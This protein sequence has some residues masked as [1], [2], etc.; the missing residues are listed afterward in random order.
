[1]AKFDIPEMREYKRE[2]PPEHFIVEIKP[3][4][5]LSNTKAEKYE[6]GVFDAGGYRWR[7]S[8]YPKYET[9]SKKG[10]ISL[11]LVLIGSVSGK[12]SPA[13]VYATFRFG[14]YSSSVYRVGDSD[15]WT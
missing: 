12:Q 15:G 11:F 10:Y 6:S 1:M 2:Y 4:S 3:Y 9:T 7:L 14:A 8:F 13:E 5:L